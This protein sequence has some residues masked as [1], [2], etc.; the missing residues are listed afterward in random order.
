MDGITRSGDVYIGRIAPRSY[1]RLPGNREHRIDAYHVARNKTTIS[2]QN[3][4]VGI[5]DYITRDKPEAAR[6]WAMTIRETRESL[7]TQPE[8]G[9]LRAGFGVRS[10]C[11]FSVGN[12]VIFFRSVKDGIEIA[13]NCSRRSRHAKSLGRPTDGL[14]DTAVNEGAINEGAQR[15]A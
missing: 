15:R 5:A 13:R 6:R 3:I 14:P 7:A 11:S 2:S 8:T 1:D 12:Y 10:C 9:E 4:I